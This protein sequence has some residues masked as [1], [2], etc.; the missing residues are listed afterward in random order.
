MWQKGFRGKRMKHECTHAKIVPYAKG[1][2]GRYAQDMRN[3]W[4]KRE[5][6]ILSPGCRGSRD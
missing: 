2:D 6:G 1:H 5:E 3:F 4:S